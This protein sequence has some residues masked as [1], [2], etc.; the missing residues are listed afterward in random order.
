VSRTITA[1]PQTIHY[2]YDKGGNVIAE[3][4]GATGAMLREYVWLGDLPIALVTG[5]APAPQYS[6]IHTGQIGEPLMVT[7]ASQARHWDVASDPWGN[8]LP[9]STGTIAQD[10]RLPG[11]QMQAESGLFQNWHRDYDPTLGRYIEADPIGLD[12]GGNV[13]AYVEGNSVNAIDPL[14]LEKINIFPGSEDIRRRAN[15]SYDKLP[16]PLQDGGTHIYG[17]GNP[18]LMC[19]YFKTSIIGCYGAKD[20]A[21][22][23]KRQPEYD[24][25]KPV[26]LWSCNTGLD[27]DGFGQDLANELGGVVYAPTGYARFAPD[28]FIGF[29]VEKASSG[30]STPAQLKGYKP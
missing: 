23:L 13:F 30:K 9:L 18:D 16:R 5:S 27:P 11:Q 8:A 15:R 7:D 20:F 1:T 21:K 22:W 12:G 6:Y 29:Y 25:S 10:L 19:V 4:D 3:H 24:P 17:H 26:Y 2:V 28:G 14:G